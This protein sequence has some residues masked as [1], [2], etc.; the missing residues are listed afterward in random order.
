M[1]K[2]TVLPLTWNGWDQADVMIFQFYDVEFTE[3]FGTFKK[4]DKFSSI[5]VNYSSGILEAYDE[6]G[7]EVVKSQK[8]VFTPID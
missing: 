7:Q 2:E 3:D 5:S 1:K 8:M 6:F 4:G